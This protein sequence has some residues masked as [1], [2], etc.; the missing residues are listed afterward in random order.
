MNVTLRAPSQLPRG[1]NL[2][3]KFSLVNAPLTYNPFS[4]K[5]HAMCA[6][7]FPFIQWT[8]CLQV[9]ASMMNVTL[10]AP[11]QLPRGHHL[12][13]RFRLVNA[14]LTFR[15]SPMALPPSSPIL[16]SEGR[17]KAVNPQLGSK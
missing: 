17:N 12:Q 9:L 6:L 3:R 16:L 1:P 4:K 14:P 15:A 11:F 7:L 8:I 2:L 10:R 13:H 5:L